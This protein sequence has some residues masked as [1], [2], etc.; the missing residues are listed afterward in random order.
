MDDLAL[1]NGPV[2]KRIELPG[3]ARRSDSATG[4]GLAGTSGRRLH[5]GADTPVGRAGASPQIDSPLSSQAF[6]RGE[7]P[8]LRQPSCSALRELQ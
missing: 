6:R 2:A 1:V 5:R 8:S 4:G 7:P 3:Y